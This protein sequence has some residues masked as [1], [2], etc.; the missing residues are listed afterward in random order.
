[1]RYA[2]TLVGKTNFTSYLVLGDD[3]VISG[4]DVALM[5]QK[6]IER[7]GVGISLHKSIL[8]SPLNGME[9]ASKLINREGNLSPLPVVLLTKQGIVAKLQFLTELVG[10]LLAGP[11]RE[12]HDLDHL[13]TSVFG[14]K[15]KDY[16]GGVWVNYFFFSLY[17]K[18]RSS[19]L[20]QGHLPEL[21]LKANKLRGI[22][23][24]DDLLAIHSTVKLSDIKALL[25]KLEAEKVS[26][27]NKITKVLMKGMITDKLSK[28]VPFMRGLG[29]DTALSR[30]E[31]VQLSVLINLYL[32]GPY[33]VFITEIFKIQEGQRPKIGPAT[34]ESSASDGH[35]MWS[36]VDAVLRRKELGLIDHIVRYG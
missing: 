4:K 9:F 20:E 13:L 29:L 17:G 33:S 7:M 32:K 1:M 24:V 16:L 28:I 23:L 15:L 22:S 2:A 18:L 5:Y 8:P 30:L 31:V 12:C 10:R 35:E 27:F 36:S 6:V 21:L 19:Q 11:V 26:I 3:V 25:L 14:P 34:L